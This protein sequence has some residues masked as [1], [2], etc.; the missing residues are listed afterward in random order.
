MRYLY[1][2]NSAYQIMEIVNLHWQRKYKE[3]EKISNYEGD[4]IILNSFDGAEGIKNNIIKTNLFSKVFFVEKT[5]NKGL[6]HV[7]KSVIDVLFPSKY[8]YDNFKLKKQDIINKYNY[9]VVPK[10]ST[11]MDAIFRLNRNAKIHLYEDGMGSY[12]AMPS[13]KPKSKVYKWL[14]GNT[15]F[16]DYEA[17]YLVMPELYSGDE[18]RLVK[19]MPEI[20]DECLE[21][22]KKNFPVS[23]IDNKKDIYW[24]AQYL[25]NSDYLKLVDNL[26]LVIGKYK[27][28]V[29]CRPHPRYSNIFDF[30]N[31]EIDS[32]K[33]SWE[34]K[35]LNIESINESLLISVHSTACF[36]PK[37]LFNEEPYIILF[38][39]LFDKEVS[40]TNDNFEELLTKFR[41][42][43]SNPNKI[44]IPNSIKE[45]EQCVQRFA[46][47]KEN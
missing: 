21:Y 41:N 3:Y 39:K 13:L 37:M 1:Y 14:N 32:S 7:V 30:S 33:E 25:N 18:H 9:L 6:F 26:L 29:L 38:Y 44:M 34:L 4:L 17:L 8:L 12:F 20:N 19:S 43:Y 42:K 24:I 45:F 47:G 16:E 22:L 46:E 28:R 2:C 10:Y 11:I 31:F 27:N 5:Y 23:N 15:N 35:I 36:T 40:N